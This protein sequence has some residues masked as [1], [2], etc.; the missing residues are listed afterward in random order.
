VSAVGAVVSLCAC[1]FFY[2]QYATSDFQSVLNFCKMRGER[3][4][5]ELSR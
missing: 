5:F 1:I 3:A 2:N 4:K